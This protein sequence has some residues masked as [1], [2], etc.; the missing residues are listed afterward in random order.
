MVVMCS[1]LAVR[2]FYIPCS[3]IELGSNVGRRRGGHAKDFGSLATIQVMDMIELFHDAA[4]RVV[5]A[6][7]MALV[8]YQ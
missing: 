1:T 7:M 5:L 6:G 3:V 8:E 4:E 2:H